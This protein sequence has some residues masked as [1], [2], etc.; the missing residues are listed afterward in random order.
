MR[1]P[2]LRR[3]EEALE[4]VPCLDQAGGCD[5]REARPGQ[6][7][8]QLAFG[9]AI[10][11]QH[12]HR[13]PEAGCAPRRDVAGLV[14]DQPARGAVEA[15]PPR[16]FLDQAGAGLTPMV[17]GGPVARCEIGMKR[18]G[19]DQI[20]TGA[21]FLELSGDLGLDRL[22]IGPADPSARN[23]RLVGDRDKSCPA[24]GHP[25][26]QRTG[27][28]LQHY[29]FTVFQIVDLADQNPVAVEKEA[30][31]AVLARRRVG[32]EPDTVCGQH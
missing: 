10:A 13:A 20:E 26:Q 15:H 24:P 29:I 6:R 3:S 7:Q 31:P 5:D 11:G 9:A 25:A 28:G 21:L 19:D 27:A 30:R 2:A 32:R 16:C 22:E 17:M 4:Q 18:A 23:A 12:M 14:A 1:F 8:R